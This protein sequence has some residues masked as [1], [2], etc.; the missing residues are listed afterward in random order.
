M[1]SPYP[2]SPATELTIPFLPRRS[3]ATA[4][5][6]L[7]VSPGTLADPEFPVKARSGRAEEIVTCIGCNQGCLDPIFSMEPVECMVNPRAG[8][9]FEVPPEKKAAK[10]KKVM[11]V[12]GGPAGLS[13]ART[14]AQAGHK[15]T[16]YEKEAYLGGQMPLSAAIDERCEMG[17]FVGPFAE[18]AKAAGAFIVS[19]VEVKRRER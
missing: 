16:L 13:A 17:A 19:G 12:G 10:P 11:V 2:S 7:S 4:A 15:V 6:T 9:E 14:A 8:R 18:Q 5:P 3:S 1:P